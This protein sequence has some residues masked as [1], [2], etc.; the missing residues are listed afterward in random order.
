M[1]SPTQWQASRARMALYGAVRGVLGGRGY[2]EVETPIL[3]PAP[4]MEPHIDPFATEYLPQTDVGSKRTLWLHTSPE[5]AMKR[6]LA[7]GVGQVF[8]LCKVFRNG[9]ISGSHNPEFTMLELY[10]PNAGYAQ[11]LEDVEALLAGC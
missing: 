1:P 3:V 5:Y 11:I 2:E 9:E 6:Q 7:D 4:G 8:Q 10:R